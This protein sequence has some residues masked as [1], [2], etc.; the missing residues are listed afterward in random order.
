MGAA[1]KNPSERLSVNFSSMS[2]PHN[3]NHHAMAVNTINDPVIT[4]TDSPVINF[5]VKLSST[6]WKR[7][8]S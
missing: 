2:D 6:K 3:H 7:V 1:M 8:F 4:D 5:A